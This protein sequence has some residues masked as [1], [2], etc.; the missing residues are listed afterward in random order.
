MKSLNFEFVLMTQTS[1][2][3]PL[4]ASMYP[5]LMAKIRIPLD[6]GA[7]KVYAVTKHIDDA[8]FFLGTFDAIWSL[9]G[10]EVREALEKEHKEGK[11]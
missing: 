1:Y 4:A 6:N 3:D 10:K 7:E 8:E 5:M 9:M 2:G 11:I